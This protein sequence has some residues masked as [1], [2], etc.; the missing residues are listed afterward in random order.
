MPIRYLSA[1]A[2]CAFMLGACSSVPRI[3]SDTATSA[4]RAGSDA[5]WERLDPDQDGFLTVAELE[6]QRGVALLRDLWR[7][8][9][10]R[11]DRVSRQEWNLWWPRMTRT[12]PSPSMQA[13]NGSA[14]TPEAR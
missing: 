9:T 14:A 8:D 3:D 10:D 5:A 6:S 2:G 13:L 12:P 1:L 11:D 4:P 7:A